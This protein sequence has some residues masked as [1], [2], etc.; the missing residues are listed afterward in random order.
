MLFTVSLLGSLGNIPSSYRWRSQLSQF[1][2]L[3]LD[4]EEDRIVHFRSR[5]PHADLRWVD[6]VPEC[7]E[8]LGQAWDVIRLD[9]DLGGEVFVNSARA[10]SG[11]EVVRYIVNNQPEHLRETVFIVHS[12]HERAAIK[13]VEELQAAGYDCTYMPFSWQD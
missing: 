8:S 4:D 1:T 2:M 12:R 7:I 6:N 11:M 5:F 3:V 13:M 10:D 9:H